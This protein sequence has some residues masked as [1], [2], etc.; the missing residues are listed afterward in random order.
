MSITGGV[1]FFDKNFAWLDQGG[2]IVDTL[3]TGSAVANNAIDKNPQ[4]YWTTVGSNDTTTETLTLTFPSSTIN[5]L[6][7]V[8]HNW[9]QFTAKYWNGASY[10]DFT[11]VSGLDGSVSA[12][13]ETAFADGTAYYEFD[14]VTTTRVQIT[15]TKTQSANAEKFINLINV[16]S[17]LGTF[18]GFPQIRPIVASRNPR[19]QT[20]IDG[21]VKVVKSREVFGVT[22]DLSEYSKSSTHTP[23]LDLIYTLHDRDTAFQIWVCGGRRGTKYFAYQNLRGFRLKDVINVQLVTDLVGE[24]A[25]GIYSLRPGLGTLEFKEHV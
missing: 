2:S 23:D 4:T 16:T 24:N 21:R 20:M 7:L 6:L 9:K 12:I 8:D 17:E 14:A 3:G 1:K 22:M 10:V 11:T 15:I 5:R 19:V 13:S 25:E 18:Q